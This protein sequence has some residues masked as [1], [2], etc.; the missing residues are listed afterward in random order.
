MTASGR[1]FLA[2]LFL[3]FLL[4]VPSQAQCSACGYFP[5]TPPA[6]YTVETG[7]IGN[8]SCT[9]NWGG[10]CTFWGTSCTNGQVGPP[11]PETYCHFVNPYDPSCRGPRNNDPPF[12][13]CAPT[14][15]DE[16]L[17]LTPVRGRGLRVIRMPDGT[18]RR[19]VQVL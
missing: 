12:I 7:I 6:C 8:T 2:A 4:P 3:C 1:L 11:T 5:G 15:E 13:A 17:R 16:V 10:G 19:F 18:I 9:S 14:I